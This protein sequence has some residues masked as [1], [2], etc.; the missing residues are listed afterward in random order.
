MAD[1]R[2]ECEISVSYQGGW[3][4]ISLPVEVEDN[5]YQSVF[6][7][8]VPGTLYSFTD[9]VYSWET[10]INYGQGY[11]LFF[12]LEGTELL[13]GECVS[14]LTIS[15]NEGWNMISAG[16]YSVDISDIGDPGGII[17]ENA[18]FGFDGNYFTPTTLE[19]GWGYW[20]RTNSTGFMTIGSEP[21]EGAIEIFPGDDINSIVDNNPEGTVFIIKIG[22]HRMQEIWPKE[23]NTFWGESGAIL[24]GSKELTEFEQE[25]GLYYAPNQTQEGNVFPGEPETWCEEGWERC[26]HS[27]DLFFDDVPLRHIPSV[28]DLA[29]GKW[30]FDY[31]E[32]RIYFADDPQGHIVE[33]SLSEFA[34]TD[35]TPANNVTIKNL[36]IEKY[37]NWIQGG[38]VGGGG[39]ITNWLIEG[40]EIRLNHGTGVVGGSS[41]IIRENYIHHQGQM[42][43]GTGAEG[44]TNVLFENNEISYNNYAHCSNESGGSKFSVTD[45]LEVIGNY[46]HHNIGPG[47]WTDIDNTNILYDGNWVWWNDYMGLSHEI[48]H[49]V[50]IRNNDFRY[51]GLGWDIWMWSSQILIHV[52]DGADVYNN[53]I[54][55]HTDG[56]NGIGIMN[57]NRP[58]PVYGDW[59]GQNNNI[60]HNEITYLGI[61]GASGIVDAGEEGTDY[62]MDYNNDSLPDWGC[63]SES[64]NNLFD[65]NI[66]HHNGIPEKFEFCGWSYLSLEQFQ[67]EGHEIHGTMDSNVIVPDDTPP[68]VCPICPGI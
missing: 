29:P 32:D 16:S 3:N 47:L 17:I 5:N 44:T 12:N 8:S 41:S 11:W 18:V 22:I 64:A 53:T 48:S 15:M 34:F 10:E 55:V 58:D 23:G 36:I 13:T 62:Y 43:V 6:P 51:N 61:Y 28:D 37:A 21:P 7:N 66:Y 38:V 40:N 67:S 1:N 14:S 25:G 26:T 57:Y 30:F 46:V 4:L 33:T 54:Y 39:Y 45:G 19:P 31:G 27:Y 63:Y 9:N 24:N 35:A 50:I 56:G 65:Y 68:Q 42:G 20:L 59:Y 49:N 60:H 2:D 52:S